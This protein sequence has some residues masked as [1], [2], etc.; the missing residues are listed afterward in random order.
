[1]PERKWHLHRAI[2]P[3]EETYPDLMNKLLFLFSDY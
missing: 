3:I 2:H 1:M